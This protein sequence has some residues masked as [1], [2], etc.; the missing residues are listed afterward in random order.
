MLKILH[1]SDGGIND[2]RIIKAA[3]TGKKNNYDVY[4]CGTKSNQKFDNI[5]RDVRWIRDKDTTVRRLGLMFGNAMILEKHLNKAIEEIRPD[6]IHA[7]NIFVARYAANF[8]IPLIFDDHEFYSM[9][10]KAKFE[11]VTS[12]KI[13]IKKYVINYLSKIWKDWEKELATNHPVITVSKPIADYYKQFTNNVFV[14]QNYPSKDAIKIDTINDSS[15]ETCSVY[16]GM[17]SN[18]NYKSYR[19]ISGLHEIFNKPNTG[20]L[21]RIGVN[22]PNNARIRSLGYV[23]MH[24]VFKIMHEQCNIGLLPWK[25]HWFHKYCNP[26]KVYEYAYCGLWLLTINDIPSIINDFDS[27]CDTFSNYNELE[28][29]LKYYNEHTDELYEK[30]NAIFRHAINN[31]IWEN[32]EGRILEAYKVA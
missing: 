22:E 5:F 15:R 9:A 30:R 20:K 1:V 21:I 6:I 28:D 17:D 24:E 13:R 32:V 3:L 26:N 7:H 12:I 4:F 18:S 19:D 16:V 29:I 11:K 27:L 23:P 31:L 2:P 8:G 14:V 25:R 10:I